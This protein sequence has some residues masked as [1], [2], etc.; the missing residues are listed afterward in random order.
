LLIIRTA[1]TV[2]TAGWLKPLNAF[3]DG[4]TP[5]TTADKKAVKATTSYRHLPN[6]KNSID[7][8]RIEKIMA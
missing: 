5:A 3:S 8:P 4:I 7:K 6:K 1:A 2:T